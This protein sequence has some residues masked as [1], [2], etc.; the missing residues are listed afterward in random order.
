MGNIWEE[1]LATGGKA[2]AV[3]FGVWL[4]QH[5]PILAPSVKPKRTAA[6]APSFGPSNHAMAAILIGRL[7]RFGHFA[8]KAVFKRQGLGSSDEFGILAA[9]FFMKRSTKM[10]LLRQCLMEEA[11]GSQMLKRLKTEGWIKEIS[12]PDDKRS[13]IIEPTA[14]GI[15]KILA[16]F[17]E[18]EAIDDLLD[19][20]TESEQKELILLLKKLDGIHSKKQ[21]LRR[22]T[23]VMGEEE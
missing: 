22:I 19:G 6:K 13:M 10:Q 20:L 1:Y 17:G 4:I 11:T 9:L 7:E 15:N 3:S 5:K 14:K 2:D 21:H 18:L 23:E 8:T 12:N 16:C